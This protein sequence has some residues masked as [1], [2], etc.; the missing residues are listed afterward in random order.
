MIN[1]DVTDLPAGHKRAVKKELRGT[2]QEFSYLVRNYINQSRQLVTDHVDSREA[3]RE[4]VEEGAIFKK[5]NIYLPA[6]YDQQDRETKYNV[7]YLLHGVGG[8][9]YEWL[10]SNSK[11]DENFIICN[12][13]DNLIANGDIEPLIIVFPNGRSA[14][15]WMDSTFNSVGT[16]MLGFYYFDYEMRNDL[17]PFIESE[18]HTCAD[19]KD[20]SP[21]GINYN[22]KHRAIAGLSMGGMQS[23]NLILGGY[24]C[25]S[26]LF[27][28]KKGHWKNGLDTTVLAPGL[29]DLFAYVGA[30][31]N[32]PTSSAGTILGASIASC[33]HR[34]H[35]LYMTCGDDDEVAM[36]SYTSSIDGLTDAAGE[37]LDNFYQ[38]LIK[39]GAHDFNV[40]NNGAYNF[41]RLSFRN[42]EEHL[43]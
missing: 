34:L 31:S 15:D 12:I 28:G 5:C 18:F 22:R 4:T 7:L 27:T 29:E 32:A 30:F 1:M 24:R 37:H 11:A 43:K 14:H 38:I 16:N 41:I 35:L 17:I 13:I 21:E 8:D 19:I 6:G 40:W 26:T 3:G 23:L 42:C 33:G 20:T 2:V 36:G 9:H 10:S 25:D 39:D